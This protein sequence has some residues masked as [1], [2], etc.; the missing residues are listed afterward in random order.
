MTR[1]LWRRRRHVVNALAA[2]GLAQCVMDLYFY[3]LPDAV[4]VPLRLGVLVMF[5][6]LLASIRV[7]DKPPPNTPLDTRRVS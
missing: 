5:T 7:Y 2:Y 4:D 3:A 1:W 6:W